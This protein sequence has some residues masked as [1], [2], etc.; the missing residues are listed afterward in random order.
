MAHDPRDTN[1]DTTPGHASDTGD[2]TF[3]NSRPASEPTTDLGERLD[4]FQLKRLIGEGG[5]GQV[6]EAWD[7]RL[8]RWVAIKRLHLAD[9][10]ARQRFLRE[11]RLQAS[12]AHPGVCP[13]FEVGQAEG[14]PYIVMP[15]L[16][17][18]H[19]DHAAAGVALEQKLVLMRQVAEAVHAAHRQGLIHRDLKPSNILVESPE[20][21]PPRPVVLD[22]GI[23]RS[24]TGEGLTASGQLV[25]TPLYMA[26]EQV[27]GT[28]EQLDR[29]T[30]VYALGATLYH[31]LAG[32][33]PHSAKGVALMLCI[34][35]DEPPRLNTSGIPIEV[36][37]IVFKCLE[38]AKDRRYNSA[39][40]LADD[41][42]RYLEG[43]PVQARRI[44]RRIRLIKWLRRHQAAVRV[45]GVA[46][47][48]LVAAL[49]WGVWSAWR[50]EERQ[51]V[52]RHFGAQIE[53]VEALVR[54]S[55]LAPLHDVR[56]DQ[57]ELRHL[58]ASIRA[59]LEGAGS[60]VAALA[61]HALGRGHLALDELEKAQHHL[62][63]AWALDLRTPEVAADLGRVLS[64][65]YRDRLTSLERVGDRVGRETLREQLRQRLDKTFGDPSELQKQLQRS[66]GEPARDLLVRGRSPVA[67]EER[68]LEALILF[69]DGRPAD[70][71][72]HLAKSPAG[73][74]WD[75]EP[76]RLE[77]DIRRSWAV[78]LHA[79]SGDTDNDAGDYASTDDPRRQLELARRA[80]ARAMEV[81]ES[82][83]AILRDDAQTI[84]LLA[85]LE[86][87]EPEEV[88]PL[89]NEGL[90][91]LEKAR[92]ANPDELRTWL[93]TARLHLLAADHARGQGHN[94]TRRIQAALETSQQA[95][96]LD[97]SSS[98]AWYGL[99][100][101]HWLLARWARDKGEDPNPH[102]DRADESFGRVAPDDRNYSYFTSLGIL[103]MA[104]AGRR[105]E[106]GL[107]ATGQYQAAV[108]AYRAAAELHSAPFAALSNLGL[109]LYN[110]SAVEGTSPLD[111]L[112]RAVETFE[113]ARQL[114][115]DHM[116]P[117]YYLGLCYLRLAQ[118]GDPASATLDDTLVE[119]AVVDL[120]RAVQLAPERFQPWVALGEVFHLQAFAAHTRGANPSLFFE[121]ARH[122]H[123][124]ALELAPGQPVA[125]LNLAWTVYF[126]GKFALRDGA[127]PTAL[128]AESEGLCRRSLEARRRAN[129]LLCLGSVRRLQ[130]EAL[131]NAGEIR[132]AG[133]RMADARL[134][135]EEI[136]SL[137]PNH[138][139]AQR[140]LGRLFTLEA[141]SLRARGENPA[142]AFERA[143]QA[144]DKALDL[145]KEILFFWLADVRW[146]LEQAEWLAA[147]GHDS[148]GSVPAIR[149]GLARATQLVPE[150]AEVAHLEARL[151]VLNLDVLNPDVLNPVQ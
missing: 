7:P 81:A 134:L 26:P 21:G 14:I 106:V 28:T 83:A 64:E 101:A 5:M 131:V 100:R 88:E 93:W 140:S 58:L 86:L 19:L 94:P 122:A 96:A 87:V 129:A 105:A 109:S 20:D 36:E 113:Q 53:E 110:A 118:G 82:N 32:H 76:L 143:R 148:A 74:S 132:E 120:E 63:A 3:P 116:V 89:L 33:P 130:A 25:G 48:F 40:A 35:R 23:A 145:E 151:D 52:A 126:E 77:G 69:H 44:D 72:Q 80:Y 107:D 65:L 85:W 137:D 9:P 133:P 135:F 22:F 43:E 108:V 92:L 66:L 70:A 115:P 147:T 98:A 102:F 117:H 112:A 84:Y 127:D 104:I 16:E 150:S 124:R 60:T 146:H 15:R 41:L 29:R 49:G 67:P 30:D 6:W 42:Q 138:A 68:M 99:G 149:Q 139:E 59:T 56:P 47:L 27:K 34:L 73:P 51:R 97:K 8:E 103:R 62:E 55:H 90:A 142:P 119:R 95:I 37:A 39:L 128:L 31:L 136:L 114:K 45:A 78:S 71:L 12:I 111:M 17:G 141:R 1:Y 4:R 10:L 2:A 125:L 54:Y 121:R 123:G 38:K 79:E 50:A 61:H 75:Y 46:A 91:S 144:L 11:A 13:V 57:A 24:I 18:E